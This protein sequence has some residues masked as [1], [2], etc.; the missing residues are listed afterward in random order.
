VRS[1]E[2][3]QQTKRKTRKTRQEER[4]KEVKASVFATQTWAKNERQNKGAQGF[5]SKAPKGHKVAQK[6]KSKYNQHG[7]MKLVAGIIPVD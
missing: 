5:R 2:A 7:R 1:K 3:N 6:Q 4:K